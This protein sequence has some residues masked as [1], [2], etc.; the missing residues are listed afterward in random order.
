MPGASTPAGWSAQSG[1]PASPTSTR[2]PSLSPRRRNCW[3]GRARSRLPCRLSPRPCKFRAL[4]PGLAPMDSLGISDKHLRAIAPRRLTIHGSARIAYK[5][6]AAGVTR[7]AD[8]YQH[9]P[10]RVLFPLH[11]ADD[12]P[13]AVL[14]T[15][16]GG[17]V[18]GDRLDIGIAAGAGA[19]LL[20]T[21][22]AAEKIY[23]SAGPDCRIETRISLGAGGWLDWLPQETIL[24]DGARLRRETRIE[25]DPESR[26]LAGE[27]LVFGRIARGERFTRG[28]ARDAWEIRRGGRLFWADALHLDGAVAEILDHPAGFDGAAACATLVYAGPDARALLEPAR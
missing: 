26:L 11:R 14:V 7:L 16:S 19:R 4:R 3:R 10:L 1:C 21:T 13:T 22:Q 8:L 25:L 18:G 24:F 20:V 6:D 28:L 17:L 23:R 27:M 9:D 15:T 2:G 5:A 12:L